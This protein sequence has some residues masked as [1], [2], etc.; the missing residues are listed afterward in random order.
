M[1]CCEIENKYLNCENSV[2]CAL[3]T[4]KNFG[5]TSVGNVLFWNPENCYLNRNI[6]VLQTP[7]N[8]YLNEYVTSYLNC[9]LIEYVIS[10]RES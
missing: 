7:E 1:L 8:S 9:D 6:L 4:K 2:I 3:C 10:S 5:L